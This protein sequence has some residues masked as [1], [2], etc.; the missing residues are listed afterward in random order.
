MYYIIIGV[1]LLLS[2]VLGVKEKWQGFGISCTV[3]TFWAFFGALFLAMM[4]PSE[5]YTTER[6]SIVIDSLT[7]VDDECRYQIENEDGGIQYRSV[8][9]YYVTV[10]D[11]LADDDEPYMVKR[12]QI[13]SPGA[14]HFWFFK[15]GVRRTGTL[16][17]YDLYV[18]AGTDTSVN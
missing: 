8:K 18:P 3:L 17:Y 13:R 6:T 15:D 11:I 7:F 2:I 9:L 16:V 12:Y 5:E 10:Y 14:R 4:I 1:L